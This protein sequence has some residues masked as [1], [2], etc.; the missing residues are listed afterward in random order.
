MCFDL[1]DQGYILHIGRTSIYDNQEQ[2]MKFVRTSKFL[3]C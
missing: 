3:V 2:G 1:E